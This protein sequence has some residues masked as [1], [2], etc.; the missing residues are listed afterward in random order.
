MTDEQKRQQKANLLL[1]YQE[2]EENLAHLRER[3]YRM[4][5]PVMRIAEW[6]G[7]ADVQQQRPEEYRVLSDGLLSNPGH[8]RATLNAEEILAVMNEIQQAEKKLAELAERKAAL[9]LK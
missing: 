3:A 6:L 7:R 2:A 5:Q 1:E 4:G 9:G 8:V